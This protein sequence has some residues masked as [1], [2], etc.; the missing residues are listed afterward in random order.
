MLDIVRC[1]H[2]RSDGRGYPQ[3]L[4]G[5]NVPELARVA[6]IADAFDSLTGGYG[7]RE[8]ITPTDALHILNA[9]AGE[10]YGHEMM[11]ELVRCLGTYPVGSLLELN[12]GAYV[13]VIGSNP[14]PG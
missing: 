2:E 6:A 3:G 11:Y 14:T 9:D 10:E 7:Y 8:P 13:M 12:S 5:D 1:H 4:H